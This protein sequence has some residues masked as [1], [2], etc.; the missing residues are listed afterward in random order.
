MLHRVAMLLIIIFWL[1]MTGLLVRNELAPDGSGIREVPMSHV[2]KLFYQHEQPSDLR[3]F[4]GSLV[5]GDVHL[6]PREDKA[7]H[8]R[9][10]DFAG[11]LQVRLGPDSLRRFSCDGL[12]QMDSASSIRH[13][14]FGITLHDTVPTRTEVE[15]N[16]ETNVAHVTLRMRTDVI[17]EGDYTLDEVGAR[18]LLEQMG[19]EP[20][21]LGALHGPSPGLS[22]QY[23]ARAS[24]LKI[25]DERVDTYL[26]SIEQAG[27]T[28]AEIHISQLGQVLK[29]T[30]LP[31]YTLVPDGVNP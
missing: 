21:L 12:L 10:L 6:Q 31:G 16:P 22:L 29:V 11:R 27:Q 3:I 17:S 7:T 8:L 30:T 14:A 4:S 26:A 15:V 25:K 19:I 13:L 28:L 9:L 23:R 1:T 5:V 2:V 18:Q 20:S 24:S